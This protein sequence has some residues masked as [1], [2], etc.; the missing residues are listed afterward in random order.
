M[1]IFE[2]CKCSSLMFF[3]HERT[4]S[5]VIY[6]PL[7]LYNHFFT[8]LSYWNFLN[9]HH[10]KKL[11][12]LFLKQFH[13]F[14]VGNFLKLA[15]KNAVKNVII[16]V[17]RLVV[18]S[19]FWWEVMRPNGKYKTIRYLS[20]GQPVCRGWL[21]RIL[22]N[23]YVWNPLNFLFCELVARYCFI[24]NYW[25]FVFIHLLSSFWYKTSNEIHQFSFSFSVRDCYR[26]KAIKFL[27]WLVVVMQKNIHKFSLK[28]STNN[29]KI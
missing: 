4:E 6:K 22:Q 3:H 1:L 24:K 17:Q 18:Y 14:Y 26:S 27:I 16:Q 28:S 9:F 25:I 15:V 21:E 13:F 10:I 23:K 8:E 5:T 29:A 2:F 7:Y 20:V 12:F 19:S 11:N